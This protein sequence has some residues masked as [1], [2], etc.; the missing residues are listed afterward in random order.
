MANLSPIH[1]GGRGQKM[2]MKMGK[3]LR[4]Y[5]NTFSSHLSCKHYYIKRENVLSEAGKKEV[6]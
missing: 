2:S 1:I 3:F 5:S 6:I 4:A